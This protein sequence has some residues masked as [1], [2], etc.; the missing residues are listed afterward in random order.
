MKLRIEGIALFLFIPLVLILYLRMPLGPGPSLAL[1]VVLMIGHRFVARPWFA[2]HV[3]ER[4]FWCGKAAESVPAPFASKGETIAAIACGE[5]HAGRIA[6]FGRVVAKARLL[7]AALILAPVVLYLLNGF[8]AVAGLPS[9]PFDAA[10]WG[11]KIPIAAAVV[12]LSFA[13][14]LGRRMGSAP[15]I[16]F[17][18]HNLFLLGI[19]NTLWVFR[20]VGIWWIV[21]GAVAV[22]G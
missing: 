20:I 11:F 22:A 12:A 9:V 21:E 15:A 6:E 7:L 1:G 18:V 14:P 3:G 4:C 2:R 8:A 19:G 5:D 10:R 16:D 17:P 13:W